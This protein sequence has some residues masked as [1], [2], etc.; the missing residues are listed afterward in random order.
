M[1]RRQG[2][3]LLRTRPGTA[4]ELTALTAW[5]DEPLADETAERQEI[6]EAAVERIRDITTSLDIWDALDAPRPS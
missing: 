4:S 3:L 5:I 6:A 1:R 2:T